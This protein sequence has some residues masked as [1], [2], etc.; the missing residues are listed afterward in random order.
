MHIT[1]IAAAFLLFA[2][3]L[4]GC[5]APVDA[6]AEFNLQIKGEMYAG[7]AK[8]SKRAPL[9]GTW[10][11]SKSHAIVFVD[12]QLDV[13]YLRFRF[14]G[15]DVCQIYV[16][17]DIFRN[18]VSDGDH[19]CRFNGKERTVHAWIEDPNPFYPNALN[20]AVD[21]IDVLRIEGTL[22]KH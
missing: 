9:D 1:R 17:R 21:I 5:S 14:E 22:A 10:T 12:W 6:A 20:V 13:A 8:F 4:T 7:T 15:D 19:R 2:N 18:F 11:D 16:A 3:A